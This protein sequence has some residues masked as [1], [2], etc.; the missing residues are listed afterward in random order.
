M[1]A[2]EKDALHVCIYRESESLC[3]IVPLEVDAYIFIAWPVHCD[4]VVFL[5]D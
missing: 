5:E 1:T 4:V 2:L 3:N